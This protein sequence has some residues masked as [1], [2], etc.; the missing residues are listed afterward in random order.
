MAGG[1]CKMS[2]WG[3]MPIKIDRIQPCMNCQA[4]TMH[5][6]TIYKD[7]EYRVC[8]RCEVRTTWVPDTDQMILDE[9]KKADP[10]KDEW[11]DKRQYPHRKNRPR[12]R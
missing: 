7:A 9:E 6:C 12:N 11:D 10:H 4:H 5:N 3:D 8:T 2:E 1:E